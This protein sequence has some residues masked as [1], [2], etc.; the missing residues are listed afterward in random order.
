VG[1]NADV[2]FNKHQPALLRYLTRYSGDPEVAADATQ[3]AYLKLVESPPSDETN[4]RAWLFTVATNVVQDG[5][6][7]DARAERL[8]NG[9]ETALETHG[10][11]DPLTFAEQMERVEVARKLLTRVS[12]KERT[13]LLMWVEGFAHKEIAEV[14]GTTT[15]TIGPTIARALKK[16]SKQID[17]FLREDL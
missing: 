8:L 5:W 12:D 14:V 3:H 6:R 4:L 7:H 17:E 1:M 13:T 9:A 16:M 11:P 15:A 10:P 2:L